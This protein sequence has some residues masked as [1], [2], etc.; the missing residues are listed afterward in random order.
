M[1]YSLFA[2]LVKS[3]LAAVL[4]EGSCGTVDW[5]AMLR[6]AEIFNFFF[7]RADASFSLSLFLFCGIRV[8]L[9]IGSI[10]TQ[11]HVINLT[12]IIIYSVFLW[13]PPIL[14]DD[15]LHSSFACFETITTCSYFQCFCLC[16]ERCLVQCRD[17]STT[18]ETHWWIPRRVRLSALTPSLALIALPRQNYW[19]L[20]WFF[21]CL[22]LC[23]IPF[24]R[25]IPRSISCLAD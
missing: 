2:C 12:I 7:S 15:F 20:V 17:C 19:V 21:S 23:R 10:E 6:A 16:A 1:G 13:Q 8:R 4:E 24:A 14:Y 9:A 22:I 11:C 25:R 5:T 3:G 18:K